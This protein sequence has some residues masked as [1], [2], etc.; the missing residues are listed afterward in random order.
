MPKKVNDF[1]LKGRVCGVLK[2]AQFLIFNAE[3]LGFFNMGIFLNAVNPH[4]PD[5][6]P[7]D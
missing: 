3:K 2:K 4:F 5:D 7:I 1:Q 6:T